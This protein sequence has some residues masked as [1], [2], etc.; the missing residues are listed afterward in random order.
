MKAW[1]EELNIEEKIDL[2]A[3]PSGEFAMQLGLL[4]DHGEML[5][6]RSRRSAL[7]AEDGV[8]A[9]FF[10]EKKGSF[11]LSTAEYILEYL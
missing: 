3:D 1:G 4:K 2:L 9:E 5:G 6:K 10:I 8:I 11:K 7:I